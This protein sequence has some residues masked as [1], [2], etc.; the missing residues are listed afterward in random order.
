ME[1]I[2]LKRHHQQKQK[3]ELK[4]LQHDFNLLKM[5]LAQ[6]DYQLNN[7]KL[8]YSNKCESLE[9]RNHQLL[10]QNQILSAKL[11]DI[12]AVHQ[13]EDR[14]KQ[15]QIKLELNRIL[16]RQKELEQNNE[17][18]MKN[19]HEVKKEIKNIDVLNWSNEEYEFM[20]RR[21]ED[22]LTIREFASVCFFYLALQY[23]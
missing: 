3:I 22:L 10:H 19:E 7:L 23:C 1:S 20:L 9:E 17:R 13:E 18:F 6:R 11:N 14:K 21:D 2:K 15:E 5:E 12:I 8:D 16:V 4:Q